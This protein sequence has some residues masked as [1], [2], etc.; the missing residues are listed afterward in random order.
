MMSKS[1]ALACGINEHRCHE[2]KHLWRSCSALASNFRSS[3]YQISDLLQRCTH[4]LVWK[5]FPPWDTKEAHIILCSMISCRNS[6]GIFTLCGSCL[7][8][9]FWMKNLRIYLVQA[10]SINFICFERFFFFL[11]LS[12]IW[13]G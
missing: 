6:R 7:L 1:N 13:I 9:H 8:I 12:L 11:T 3:L 4:S 5:Q 10:W 2:I